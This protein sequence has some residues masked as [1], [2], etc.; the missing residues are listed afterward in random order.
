M[1]SQVWHEIIN[2]FPIFN[3]C[4]IE[5]CE[6][7]SNLIPHIIIDVITYPGIKVKPC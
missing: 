4:I 3:G 6:W 1:P 2:S 5:V 7:V